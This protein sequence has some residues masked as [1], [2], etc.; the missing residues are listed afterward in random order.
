[1]KKRKHKNVIA[2]CAE[3]L[4]ARAQCKDG[5]SR[6]DA[7]LLLAFSMRRD[8]EYLLAH[9]ERRAGLCEFFRFRRMVRAR[10]AGHP[11]AHITG[12]REF[13]GRDFFITKAVLDP[14]PETELLVSAA[15][16]ELKKG[17]RVFVDVGTGS[18]CIAVSV[19]AELAKFH[20]NGL[21]FFATDIS[22]GALRNAKKNARRHGASIS[23]LRGNLLLPV[24]SA[25]KDAPT[26]ITANLPYLTE[27]E[28]LDEPSIRR[29]PRLALVAKD[30]G[31]SLY[32][33]MLS[34]IHQSFSVAPDSAYSVS[35]FMECNPNQALE[36]AQMSRAIFPGSVIEIK[37]DLAGLDRMVSFSIARRTPHK[38]QS[39]RQ[40]QTQYRP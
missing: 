29:E 31:L 1:M 5:I 34:Q 28:Y 19:A 14:R 36:L 35:C 15:L 12:S 38:T 8:K 13:Y 23:F 26:V 27:R 16:C 33:E 21:H 7:E 4:L 32:R 20:T 30:K 25:L 10:R 6:L 17:A 2:R 24:L 18:G 3:N 37:K 40:D 11:V 22:R 9:P 39:H